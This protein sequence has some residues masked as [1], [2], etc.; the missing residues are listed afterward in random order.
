MCKKEITLISIPEKKLITFSWY[1]NLP[2][3]LINLK[4]KSLNIKKKS[5]K[6]STFDIFSDHQNNLRGYYFVRRVKK[7]TTVHLKIF[8]R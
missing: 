7:C 2:K 5:G 6:I 3:Y 1:Q 8:H 4:K